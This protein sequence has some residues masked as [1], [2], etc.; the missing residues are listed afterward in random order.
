MWLLLRLRRQMVSDFKQD[1]RPNHWHT[2]FVVEKVDY[3]YCGSIFHDSGDVYG[4]TETG[5]MKS[6]AQGARGRTSPTAPTH[7]VAHS[8]T[9]TPLHNRHKHGPQQKTCLWSLDRFFP[10]DN[11]GHT[12]AGLIHV[13]RLVRKRNLFQIFAKSQDFPTQWPFSH[14]FFHLGNSVGD[15]DWLTATNRYGSLWKSICSPLCTFW[16]WDLETNHFL[17]VIT[18]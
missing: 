10:E 1:G 8:M 6:V 11:Q 5:L 7:G 2:H 16:L 13:L 3:G 15:S 14:L 18:H 9:Q 17:C 12:Q 4:M